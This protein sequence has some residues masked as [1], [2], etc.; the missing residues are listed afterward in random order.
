VVAR[1]C[2]LTIHTTLCVLVLHNFVA[3]AA[4][5]VLRVPHDYVM[6][7]RWGVEGGGLPASDVMRC[8]TPFEQGG[9]DGAGPCVC[10]NGGARPAR[11]LTV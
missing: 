9:A 11:R 4:S 1:I 6:C 7:V 3:T 10:A 8:F 2:A 5:D